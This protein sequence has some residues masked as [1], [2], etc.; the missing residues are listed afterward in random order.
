[1]SSS[2]LH[3]TTE[4]LVCCAASST[5]RASAVK[6]GFSMS[7][8][9]S[10]MTLP[11]CLRSDWATRLGEKPRSAAA[12]RTRSARSGVTRPPLK[13]R[14]TVAGDTPAAR[15]TSVMVAMNLS[16]TFRISSGE[17]RCVTLDTLRG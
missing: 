14:D 16:E 12:R 7:G 8:I 1:M 6:N 11:R 10:P 2:V 15:A 17:A 5:P 3:S 13:T 4:R 9:S